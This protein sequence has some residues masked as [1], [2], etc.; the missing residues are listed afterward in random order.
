MTEMVLLVCGGAA[1]ASHAWLAIIGF[2]IERFYKPTQRMFTLTVGLLSYSVLMMTLATSPLGGLVPALIVGPSVASGFIAS[3][4]MIFISGVVQPH[5]PASRWWLVLGL[6]GAAYAVA[7]C[8]I[9]GGLEALVQFIHFGSNIPHPVLT[10]MFVVHSLSLCVSLG[11]GAQ[12]IV[13]GFRNLKD[14]QQRAALRWLTFGITI[15][16]ILLIFGNIAPLIGHPY[17]VRFVPVL[18]LPVGLLCYRSLQEQSGLLH[19]DRSEGKVAVEKRLESLGRMARGVSHDINNM[20]TSVMGSA[21]LIRVKTKDNQELADHLDQIVNTSVRAGQ[22]MEGMLSFSG[23]GKTPQAV[24]PKALLLEAIQASQAQCPNNIGLVYGLDEDLPWVQVAPQDLVNAVLNLVINGFDAI[25]T[26]TGMVELEAKFVGSSIIP[27][28][29]FGAKLDGHPSMLITVKDDG[30]GMDKET[31]AHIYEPFF[32]TKTVGRG[33]GLMSVFSIVQHCGGAISC[34]S[35]VG[36]GT[37]F[38]LWVPVG[39]ASAEVSQE[40]CL[41]LSQCRLVLVEDNPDVRSVLTE[42][43]GTMHVRVETHASA[44]EA[45]ASVQ[46]TPTANTDVYLLDIRLPRQSGVDLAH[47]I[48]T[49]QPQ[50]RILFMSGD[51]HEHTMEQFKEYTHVGF[52]RKPVNMEALRAA[53]IGVGLKQR[54]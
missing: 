8:T 30:C 32:S 13:S 17:V 4:F 47:Q 5:K 33:L 39:T 34:E 35:T 40:G 41:D 46:G 7:V 36:V 24:A 42:V 26:Q 9:D 15:A 44:E 16:V 10:P 45:W 1:A 53:L 29:A 50:A 21:E 25:G 54:E 43:L 20:L 6:P 48:L 27:A 14:P 38:K 19:M 22:L 2:H 28:T 12:H 49:V 37:V 23:P 18:T 3:S 51:E 31:Q 11:L 52:M